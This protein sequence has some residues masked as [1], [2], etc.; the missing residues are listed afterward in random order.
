MANEFLTFAEQS[1]DILDQTNYS[2]D[3]QRIYGVSGQNNE[4]EGEPARSNLHNKLFKQTS[5]IAA[6]IGQY[7]SNSGLADATD[8]MSVEDLVNYLTGSVVNNLFVTDS[9]SGSNKILEVP[10]LGN[11]LESQLGKIVF[12][13]AAT[14]YLTQSSIT[15]TINGI[16]RSALFPYVANISSASPIQ[17]GFYTGSPYMVYIVNNSQAHI[18][19]LTSITVGTS[20]RAGKVQLSDVLTNTA[21]ASSGQ[22]AATPLAVKNVNDKVV[23]LSD[24]LPQT[25]SFTWETDDWGDITNGVKGTLG[26]EL[27]ST[28]SSTTHLIQWSPVVGNGNDYEVNTAS[29]REAARIGLYLSDVANGNITMIASEPPTINLELQF[30]YIGNK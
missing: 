20:S 10:Y 8:S 29:A 17:C 28:V 12:G 7:I 18:F 4:D 16:Q 15:I 21:N 1:N 3:T 26:G 11:T 24:K 27:P 19:P 25:V 5:L 13:R 2:S 6:V 22:T 14:T 9:M 30:T 23:S